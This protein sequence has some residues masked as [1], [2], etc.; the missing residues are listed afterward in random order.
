MGV[1]VAVDVEDGHDDPDEVVE[2]VGHCLV[3]LVVVHEL[4]SSDEVAVGRVVEKQECLRQYPI[5]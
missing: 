3:R 4:S 5:I 2:H 1:L